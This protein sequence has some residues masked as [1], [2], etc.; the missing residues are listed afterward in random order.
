MNLTSSS[1]RRY[2]VADRQL[3]ISFEELT[4]VEITCV[5]GTGIVIPALANAPQL[6]SLCP[7]CRRSYGRAQA[8]VLAFRQL[9]SGAKEFIEGPKM[10]EDNAVPAIAKR[11]VK[12]RVCVREA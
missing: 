8:A 2:D 12:F 5:C 1:E 9:Y 4:E 3:L 10:E 7:G 11:S 6:Q